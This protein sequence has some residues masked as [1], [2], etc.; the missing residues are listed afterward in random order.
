MVFEFINF[1]LQC[2]HAASLKS[3]ERLKEKD[4]QMTDV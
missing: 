1:I 4:G 2:S 3:K